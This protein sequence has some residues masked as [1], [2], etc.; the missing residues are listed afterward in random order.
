[1]VASKGLQYYGL[2]EKRGSLFCGNL[3]LA[4]SNVEV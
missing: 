2:P 3:E 4:I 1:M